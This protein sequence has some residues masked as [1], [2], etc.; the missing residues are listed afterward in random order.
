M[1]KS[2]KNDCLARTAHSFSPFKDDRSN[3]AVVWLVSRVSISNSPTPRATPLTRFHCSFWHPPAA[4]YH[5]C[6]FVPVHSPVVRASHPACP[7]R[8]KT[9]VR[10]IFLSAGCPPRSALVRMLIPRNTY[11]A[12][13]ILFSTSALDLV[14]YSDVSAVIISVLPRIRVL[15]ATEQ[16][17]HKVRRKLRR[18]SNEYRSI[19]IRSRE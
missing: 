14:P 7:S 17:V 18:K 10:N 12:D 6:I 8:S 2:R 1:Q 16:L 4:L 11:R 9:S 13:A 19:I 5:L 3:E 15:L